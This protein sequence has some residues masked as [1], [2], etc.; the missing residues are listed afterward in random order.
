MILAEYQGAPGYQT[1]DYRTFSNTATFGGGGNLQLVGTVSYL[2]EVSGSTVNMRADYVRN[3]NTGG[4]SGTLKLQ[5]WATSSPFAG[6]TI[7]GYKFGEYTLGTL[8]GG[9]QFTNINVN[10]PFTSPPAG[11]YYVSMLLAEYQGAPGYQTVDYRTFSNTATFGI[12]VDPTIAQYFPYASSLGGGWYYDNQIGYIYP[13]SNGICYFD[14]YNYYYYPGAGS[15]NY[16]GGVYIYDFRYH[17]W[18]YTNKNVWPYVYYY[19][20]GQWYSSSF[21]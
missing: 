5:L 9:F 2:H 1:I 3:N 7:T 10:P 8:N 15:F 11:T 13:F 6:G 19:D 20:P 18:T 16:S 14:T 4:T 21:F 12:V 17:S